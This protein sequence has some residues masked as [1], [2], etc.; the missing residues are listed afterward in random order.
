MDDMRKAGLNPML[1]YKQGG[2]GTLGGSTYT[3]PNVGAAAAQ[4]A[5]GGATSS[6][7]V[8]K[9][10]TENKIRDAQVRATFEQAKASH[11]QA[12]KAYEETATERTRRQQLEQEI[13]VRAADVSSAKH[14]ESFYNS[15]VGKAAKYIELGK[16][17]VNPLGGLFKK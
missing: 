1:A 16:K 4:G 15:P 8:A 14:V 13:K 11:W 7:T 12:E 10:K 2:A 5:V 6:A 9:E 17:S 3:P